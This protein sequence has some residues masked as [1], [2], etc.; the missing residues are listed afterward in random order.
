MTILSTH[1]SYAGAQV[2]LKS[3]DVAQLRNVR[4]HGEL[5]ATLNR[6]IEGRALL[7]VG[8]HDRLATSPWS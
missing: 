6:A 7:P 3:S 2:D 1:A 5:L 8:L 4:P